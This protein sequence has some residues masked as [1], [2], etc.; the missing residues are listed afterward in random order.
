MV[1]YREISGWLRFGFLRK[2]GQDSGAELFEFAIV[3]PLLLILLIGILWVG[4]AY[5]IYA[6]ITRA[7]REGA[8]YAVLPSSM[9]LGGTEA[10]PPTA[11]CSSNTNTFNGH[12][13]P[14]LQADNLDPSKVLGYCQKAAW[15]EN[16]YPQQC[17]VIISFSYPVQLQ[18]P[19]TPLNA[20]TINIKT[21]AQM[22]LENQPTGG[23]CP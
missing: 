15:L 9:A 1:K 20:T 23:T 17:G 8:R 13:V 2:C 4:R 3:A 12:I 22:R 11:A 16:T 6:T 10:D 7:A 19:F 18:I 5:N 14:A 21:Q